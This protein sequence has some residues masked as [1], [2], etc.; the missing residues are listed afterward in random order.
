MTGTLV[1][2]GAI[3]I[4]SLIGLLFK[5]GISQSLNDIIMKVV[6]LVVCIIGLNG[7]IR[8]MFTVDLETGRLDWNGALLL[9]IS[10]MIGCLLGEWLQLD[11]RLTQFGLRIERRLGAGGFAKGFVSATLLF[12]VGAMSIVGAINDGLRGDSSVLLIKSMLDGTTSIILT[13]ALGFGVLFSAVPVLLYQGSI[14]LLSVFIAPYISDRLLDMVYMVGYAI[15]IFIGLN[16]LFNSQ[17]KTANLLPGLA[18]PVV[19]YFI[20]TAFPV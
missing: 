16:F 1:N 14:S 17:I 10:L 8:A 3:I 6:G 20:T 13:S 18:V 5:K 9:L 7:V 11:E 12:C 15:V 4:G 2:A 19:Y